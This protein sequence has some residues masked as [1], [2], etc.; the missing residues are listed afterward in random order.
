MGRALRPEAEAAG[1]EVGLEDRFE[2][3][4]RRRHRHPIAK[5]GDAERPCLSRLP[6]LGDAH[7]PQWRG[8]IRPD[9]Q[10][11]GELIEED[12]HPGLLDGFDAEAVDGMK[13]EHQ[14][15][16]GG[17]RGERCLEGALELAPIAQL[18]VIQL[19]IGAPC[20]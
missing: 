10:C 8:P 17:E 13:L 14:P 4:L 15:L 16:A 3:Q 6:G 20:G 1:Q 12:R 19:G 18:Q 11:C 2:D 9:P 7:P 5:T